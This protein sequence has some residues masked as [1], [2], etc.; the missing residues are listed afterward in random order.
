[1]KKDICSKI[2]R[3]LSFKNISPYFDVKTK[4]DMVLVLDGNSEYAAH[5]ESFQKVSLFNYFQIKKFSIYTYFILQVCYSCR[6]RRNR[7]PR[8]SPARRYRLAS[9]VALRRARSTASA[10]SSPVTAAPSSPPSPCS[11]ITWPG[12][13]RKIPIL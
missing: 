6:A 2:S 4:S 9:M 10:G 1:M 11:K 8:R 7:S 13:I 3:N 12:H 5:S